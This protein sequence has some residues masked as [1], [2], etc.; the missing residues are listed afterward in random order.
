[1]KTRP[2]IATAVSILSRRIS[3]PTTKD[4]IAVKRVMRYL[5]GTV[6]FKLKLPARKKETVYRQRTLKLE[7][8]LVFKP[9]FSPPYSSFRVAYNLLPFLS[10]QQTPCE[11]VGLREDCD[12]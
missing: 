9:R 8:E 11:W 12:C 4:W 7:E 3:T 1:M 5:K 2:D 10:P 6:H